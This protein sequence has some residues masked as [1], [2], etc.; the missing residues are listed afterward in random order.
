M[1]LSC[2]PQI[3]YHNLIF[4]AAQESQ[5]F[6]LVADR[7][8]WKTSLPYEICDEKKKKLPHAFQLGRRCFAWPPFWSSFASHRAKPH[9]VHHHSEVLL[10]SVD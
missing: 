7:T 2:P 6:V 9:D 3:R 5:L 4:L 8:A 1:S 10:V